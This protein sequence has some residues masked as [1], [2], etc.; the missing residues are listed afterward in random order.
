V[1]AEHRDAYDCEVVSGSDDEPVL[2]VEEE[3][4]LSL[5][6]SVAVAPGGVGKSC[7]ACCAELGAAVEPEPEPGA[8][9]ELAVDAPIEPSTAMT[10]KATANVA[11]AVARTWRRSRAMRLTRSSLARCAAARRSSVEAL[12]VGGIAGTIRCACEST[13][14]A[15]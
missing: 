7:C 12:L 15:A 4:P 9:V 10:A 3:E 6:P 8:E 13:A 14:S 1:P 2:A 11:S 5:K